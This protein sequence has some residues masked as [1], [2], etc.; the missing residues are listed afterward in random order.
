MVKVLI[1][2]PT[3]NTGLMYTKT[4]ISLIDLVKPPKFDFY[5]SRGGYID[6]Q[7]NSA[8]A[9]MLS[10][11]EFT[12]IFFVDSDMVIPKDALIK[13]FKEDKGIISGLYFHRNPPHEP[14]VYKIENSQLK[15]IQDYHK[16]NLVECDAVGA[17]CLLIKRE[18]F[19]KL[20]EHVKF[21]DGQ[22]QFFVTTPTVG[23][24][25]FFCELAKKH[26]FQIFSDT[27]VKCGHIELSVIE[28]NDF[29]KTLAP[30]TDQQPSL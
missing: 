16:D 17:G 19:E 28:E 9:H 21:I 25:I 8:A 26:G 4:F 22:H 7:R 14:H 29:I 5:F 1:A 11:P 2:M 20:N 27:S 10:D 30:H 6:S 15:T 24:D 3:P 12:H 18:V 13:L 23:E